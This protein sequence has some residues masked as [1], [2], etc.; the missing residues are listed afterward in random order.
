MVEKYEMK[1]CPTVTVIKIISFLLSLA[2]IATFAFTIYPRPEKY[3]T[4][5]DVRES[6]AFD[7]VVDAARQARI[8]EINYVGSLSFRLLGVSWIYAASFDD[9]YTVYSKI[10]YTVGGKSKTAY[11]KTYCGEIWNNGREKFVIDSEPISKEF[12]MSKNSRFINLEQTYNDLA[13]SV[14]SQAM[15]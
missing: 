14:V 9:S 6:K 7:A 15:K 8:S 5:A 3:E 1:S 12:Y 11:Y 4:G 2:V 13:V 10:D